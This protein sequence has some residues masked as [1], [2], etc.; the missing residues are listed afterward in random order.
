ML[1]KDKR[2]FV[3][4]DN[5][6]NLA[7]IS[8][9][10]SQNGATVHFERWGVASSA[11]LLQFMPAEVARQVASVLNLDELLPRLT[12]L[13][14]SSFN[15]YH[16]QLYLYDKATKTLVMEAAT[17]DAGTTVKEQRFDVAI[18]F[19][20]NPVARAAYSRKVVVL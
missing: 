16:T 12:E 9:I 11:R 7:I 17:G 2:V 6:G 13:T 19:W 14:N 8:L 20:P 4:E 3:V 5:A 15:L 10:L 18:E 1:L